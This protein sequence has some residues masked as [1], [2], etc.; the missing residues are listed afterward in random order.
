MHYLQ[1]HRIQQTVAS[2]LKSK[3]VLTIAHR[4]VSTLGSDRILVMVR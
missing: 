2:E 1:D 3:T 4:V